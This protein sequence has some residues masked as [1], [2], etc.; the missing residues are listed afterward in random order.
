MRNSESLGYKLQG[1]EL[2]SGQSTLSCG[3]DSTEYG[4][5][6]NSHQQL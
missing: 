5:I 3:L 1:C 4:A 2:S 6:K